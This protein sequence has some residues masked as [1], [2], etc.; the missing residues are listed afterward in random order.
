L[1]AE[2]KA[3]ACE[4]PARVGLPLSRFSRS[5]LRR[6]VALGL[7]AQTSGVTLW[8]WLRRDALRPWTR[9]SW[10]FPRDPHFPEKAARVLDL[11]HRIWEG[12]PLDRDEYVLSADEKTQVQIRERRHP[13]TPPGPGRA[14]RMEHEYRRH[15][16]RAYIAAWDVHR[17]KLFG[18]VADRST[19]ASFDGLAAEVMAQE[20]YRSAKRVFWVVDNGTVHRGPASVRRLR[21]Q[22]PNLVLVHLPIHASWLNQVE[23][24][25]SVE[26]G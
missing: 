15:G 6:H 17:A 2:V 22:W 14:M 21:D 18:R 8:Q 5:D 1:V 20:P 10:I 16:T 26:P 24:Y 9:R 11:Y 25:F 4:L 12:Y 3:I 13:V 19:I 23:I 7:V